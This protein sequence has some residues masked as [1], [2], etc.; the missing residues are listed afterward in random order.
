MDAVDNKQDERFDLMSVQAGD[1]IFVFRHAHGIDG[2]LQWGNVQGQRVL[3]NF[4]STDRIRLT[5]ALPV[6][7]HVMLGT[8]VGT[9]IHA[10]GTK[11]ALE[12]VT[13]A[14][15]VKDA[16]YEIYRNSLIGEDTANSIAEAGIH[17][18]EQAYNFTNYFSA[19]SAED[20]TQ[21]CSSL[22]AQAY[23]AVGMPLSQRPDNKVL[24]IDLHRSC[25]Q[26]GWQNVTALSRHTPLPQSAALDSINIPVSD[27]SLSLSEFFEKTDKLIQEGAHL[28]VRNQEALHNHTRQLVQSQAVIARTSAALF[29]EFQALREAPARMTIQ[30]AQY[31][32][33][34]LSQL[35]NLLNLA[36]LPDVELLLKENTINRGRADNSH[37]LY[38]G[39]PTNPEIRD[40]EKAAETLKLL[41]YLLM[42]EIGL[43]C[44]LSR[45]GENPVIA[46]FKGVDASYLET[47]EN[48]LPKTLSAPFHDPDHA[49]PWVINPDFQAVYRAVYGNVITALKCLYPSN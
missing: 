32:E 42:A 45:Y 13:D 48:A 22:V 23:R 44:I 17:Y 47:F 49:Y 36:D 43:C 18:L 29:T 3:A 10:D 38:A 26:P 6:F 5:P 21:F 7:S 1:I 24:P 27:E 14:L 8:G 30:H 33:R 11:V 2:L 15:S 20:A 35:D 25:Q 31:I 46:K 9:I 4:R 41:A 40:N 34:T 28:H 19:C 16:S 37:A 12:V 39:L